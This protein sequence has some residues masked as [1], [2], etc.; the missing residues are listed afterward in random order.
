MKISSDDSN[1]FIFYL[2]KRVFFFPHPLIG[3][4]INISCT[5]FMIFTCEV[6]GYGLNLRIWINWTGSI[7][8][9]GKWVVSGRARICASWYEI[10]IATITLQWLINLLYSQ[11][12]NLWNDCLKSLW[13]FYLPLL[14]SSFRSYHILWQQFLCLERLLSHMHLLYSTL[15]LGP[16]IRTQDSFSACL[17]LNC[18]T[19]TC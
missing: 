6:I 11:L 8:Y 12:E 18:C 1:I 9:I 3:Y 17:I 2:T 5:C 7:I 10:E 14:L 4:V 13:K 19:I 16:V 15:V